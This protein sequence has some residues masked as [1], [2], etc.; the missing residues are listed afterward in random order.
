VN[1]STPLQFVTPLGLVPAAGLSIASKNPYVTGNGP[2]LLAAKLNV[3]SSLGEGNPSWNASATA[4]SGSD[5]YGSSAWYRLRLYTSAGFSPDGVSSIFPTD[6]SK[7]FILSAIGKD[8]SLV[9]L[10]QTGV[11]YD[12]PGLGNVTIIGLADTGL[13]QST[14]NLAYVEDHDN[15][16]D[17]ILTGDADAIAS[18]ATVRMPS[19]GNYSAVYNPGG[20]G[21]NPASNNANVPFTVPSSDQ[22]VNITNNLS[23]GNYVTYVTIGCVPTLDSSGQPTGTLQGPAV[24]NN[25][26]G[27]TVNAYIDT[28]NCTFYSSFPVINSNQ[29]FDLTQSAT[30]FEN[31]V[32]SKLTLAFSR[33]SI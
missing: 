31:A 4:N 33:A 6:F 14:Y 7:Y 22:T 26:T 23:T 24:I 29:R 32:R 28:N 18:L 21:N 16:Y 5:L 9:E 20:P 27:Y 30:K 25:A 19:S 15:Q 2:R 3:F 10:T 1:A 13:L 17:V 11:R 8:G 12:I